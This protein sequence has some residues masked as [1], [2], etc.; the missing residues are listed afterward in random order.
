M[1]ISVVRIEVIIGPSS[2][3]TATI[4]RAGV[5]LSSIYAFDSRTSQIL[6]E[7][8][9]LVALT[10]RNRRPLLHADSYVLQYT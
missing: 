5:S 10:V 2:S 7:N 9:K 4:H 1:G 8:W 6:P 3:D